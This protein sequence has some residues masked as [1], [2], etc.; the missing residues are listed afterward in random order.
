[1]AGKILKNTQGRYDVKL[2]KEIG[3]KAGVSSDLLKVAK[4][5]GVAI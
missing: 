1:M 2:L 3:E 4:R 5:Y